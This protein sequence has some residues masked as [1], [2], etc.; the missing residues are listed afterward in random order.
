MSEMLMSIIRE[1]PDDSLARLAC[2]D[3][4]EEQGKSD[5]AEFIRLQVE[6]DR[7]PKSD[8]RTCPLII[9]SEAL[10]AEHE[11]SWLGEWSERLVRWTFR[12]GFLDS[13]VLQPEVFLRYGEELLNQHPVR[14][15]RF[16]TEEG[17]PAGADAIEDL[18]ASPAFARVRALDASGAVPSSGPAWCRALARASRLTRW[19]EVNFSSNWR[20]GGVF[21]D[22]EALAQLC[23]A[24]HLAGLKQLSLAAPMA[25][26]ALGDEAVEHITGSVFARS[27][28]SLNLSGLRLTD[29]SLRLLAASPALSG[30]RTLELGWCEQVTREGIQA[31]LDSPHLRSVEELSLGGDIDLSALARSE[32]LARLHELTLNTNTN[33]HFRTFPGSAWSELVRSPHIAGLRRFHLL[34]ALLDEDGAAGLLQTPGAL[35]LHALMIMGLRGNGDVLAGLL[36]KS[37]ALAELTALELP[38]CNLSA[39]GLR[40]L[41]SAEFVPGLSLFC[42]AGNTI[43]SRGMRALLS[44]PLARGRLTELHLHHCRLQPGTLRK[45]TAWRGLTN[46]TKLELGNN[47]FDLSSMNALLRSGHAQRLTTLHLGSARV[48]PEAL[49]ALADSTWLPRLRDVTIPTNT[50]ETTVQALRQ[51][52]GAR[53]SLDPAG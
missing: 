16:I 43:Q 6:I 51:R 49:E 28:T 27:L 32:R 34:Y 24:T 31:L 26:H 53:L 46:V 50:D 37:P 30:L 35:R 15:V 41:L 2:A 39:A 14:E 7:L 8:P 13:V 3:W 22:L 23:R 18:A 25:G 29:S 12:R 40:Q 19:E 47:S 45:L 21:D 42:V 44:S 52:F 38:G 5:R 33:Q 11:K 4:W 48:Q 9:R 10:L 36:S 17:R 20:E 1:Q